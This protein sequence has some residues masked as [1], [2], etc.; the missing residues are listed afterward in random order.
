M[1]I[2]GPTS[3]PLYTPQPLKPGVSPLLQPAGQA[4]PP[5]PA[6]PLTPPPPYQPIPSSPP[7]YQAIAPGTPP[8]YQLTSPGGFN[9]DQFQRNQTKPIIQLDESAKLSLKTLHPFEF[10][11]LQNASSSAPGPE[12][13]YESLYM[14]D[15]VNK[16][17]NPYNRGKL[18]ALLKQ[19]VLQNSRA[20]DG[21]SAL[22]HIYAMLSTRRAQGYD[23]KELVNE[24]V[25]ILN[26]PY[27]IT[28]KFAP[29]S[30]EATQKILMARNY[31]ES[32][33]A[34]VMPPSRLLNR[35]DL[36]VEDSGTCVSSS[37]MYYMADREPAELARHLNELTSPLNAFFEK[38]RLDEISPGNPAEAI[39]ILKENQIP[40]SFTAPGEVAVKVNLPPAGVLRAI[41]S[42]YAPLDHRYR[43]AIETAYQS[44]LTFL[45]D[46]TYDSA[47][48]KMDM[49]PGEEG[50]K[51]VTEEKKTLMQTITQENGGV[52]SVTYQAVDNKMN[53]LPGEENNSYLY[54]YNRPF[55]QTT[56]DIIQSLKM[57]E[58]VVVG[59]TDTDET[60][61][62]V[63]GHEITI[64][65]AFNDP[66]DH[67]LKFNVADSDDGKPK[68]VV[69]T[70]R[71]LIPTIHHAGLPLHLA[72]RINQEI[73][74][75]P[76]IL[77]PDYKD[78]QNFKLLQQQIGPM[79]SMVQD[80]SAP[81]PYQAAAPGTPLPPYQAITP[82]TLPPYQPN[83]NAQ[84]PGLP[85]PR[86]ATQA[87]PAQL[88]GRNPFAVNP[89][90]QSSRPVQGIA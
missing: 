11:Q 41:D 50:Q 81:P 39:N 26:R 74:T 32:N 63:T 76:G 25:D 1:S 17:L 64:T 8:S 37:V 29:L 12:G 82:A 43:N 62:I 6:S 70:A 16:A 15:Q 30:E 45:A 54:G 68:L 87:S 13:L 52:Q 56:N 80:G 83:G 57:K 86:P 69:K 47:T 10:K 7:P 22:Y 19:G 35:N 27:E 21:H 61:A 33:R 78:S 72:Q 49:G 55:E 73:E 85:A 38:A 88:P 67:Q 77:V 4:M 75:T 60:G 3:F 5:A 14:Y 51:G 40:F 42:Q 71:E 66:T 90:A 9:L 44:A 36:L 59:T 58:P 24:T 53:P 20:E 18:K 28:Q 89:F 48:D 2:A 79:P 34:G 84:I 65:G 23:A 46:H 31:P